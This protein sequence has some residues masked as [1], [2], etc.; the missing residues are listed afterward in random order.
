MGRVQYAGRGLVHRLPWP[1]SSSPPRAVIPESVLEPSSRNAVS[2]SSA[3]RKRDH[4]SQDG[5]VCGGVTGVAGGNGCNGGSGGG[6]GRTRSSTDGNSPTRH[7]NCGQ[8]PPAAAAS[9]E[10]SKEGG[11]GKVGSEHKKKD[12]SQQQEEKGGAE[13]GEGGPPQM[14]GC[15]CPCFCG[16][17]RLCGVFSS[18]GGS[19]VVGS[20]VRSSR[21]CRGTVARVGSSSTDL[22]RVEQLVGGAAMVRGCALGVGFVVRAAER[23]RSLSV[24]GALDLLDTVTNAASVHGRTGERGA[25]GAGGGGGG[26]GGLESLF[27][28][29]SSEGMLVRRE[30]QVEQ[31]PQQQQRQQTAA[32]VP[33]FCGGPLVALP[34]R[35]EVAAAL[36]RLPG[37]KFRPAV[38]SEAVAAGGGPALSEERSGTE[39]AK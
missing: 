31:Q 38:A 25:E 34:R 9:A 37:V 28:R 14:T 36:H 24:S 20:D 35:F 39:V 1:E 19:A 8:A 2:V 29:A 13:A 30:E 4:D 26:G 5:I 11:D 17:S 32:V 7:D 3:K 22:S 18:S 16:G 10:L 21:S 6:H 15:D 33:S 23:S 12:A 27:P